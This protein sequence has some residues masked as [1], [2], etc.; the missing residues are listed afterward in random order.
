[1]TSPQQGVEGKTGL[2]P[3]FKAHIIDIAKL[4]KVNNESKQ[5]P[6]D[7]PFSS[8]VAS[9]DVIDPPFNP[10]QLATMP[11]INSELGPCINAM[12][13]N[14]DG[15]G[16]RLV[17][18]IDLDNKKV[19]DEL[20]KKVAAESIRM[21]NFFLYAGLEKSFRALRKDT[22]HDLETT[23]NAYWE[24]VRGPT[25]DIQYFKLMKS[26]QVRLTPES[27]E[28]IETNM[29]IVEIQTDGSFEIKH[30]KVMRR[31]RKFVQVTSTVRPA[32]SSIGYRQRWF[33]AF[34]DPRVMDNE[35]GMIIEGPEASTY[36][37]DKRANEVI[38]FK[39]YCPRSP[40]GLPRYIGVLMSLLGDRKS[41][42]INYVTLCNNN[43]P[44]LLIAVSNGY[45]TEGSVKRIKEYFEKLQGDENRSKVLVIEAESSEDDSGEE[46]GQSRIMIKELTGAQHT[47]AMYQEYGKGN[48][49]RIRVSY[50]LPPIFLG[51]SD[52]YTRATAESSRKLADEQ[53]FNPERE[54]FDD[55]MN[56]IV[57]PAMNVIYHLFKS[58]SPNT[59]DNTELVRILSGAEKTGGMTPRIAR[60]V[61][62]DV[63]GIDLPSFPDDFDP[64]VPFSLTM[65]EAVKNLADA[66]EPGQ[67]VTAVKKLELL[68]EVSGEDAGGAWVVDTLLSL[69][70]QLED[71]W[72]Q[73]ARLPEGSEEAA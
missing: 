3:A 52:D 41:E 6:E 47:D 40:Y 13:G 30:R 22:R 14:I 11:E 26:Y 4:D 9:G 1:M 58:N 31:F 62:Q 71:A 65:A 16:Y 44:S 12:K 70:S 55:F 51:R 10:F 45:L 67:Q 35:S 64:D 54:D 25:G 59:T 28:A 5:L 68:K 7:D 72:E 50:R 66:T 42:E 20:R 60:L 33:K 53:V 56:R 23:G 48:R 49:E 36:P 18:R 29:P 15:F 27:S 61:L 57:F 8:L 34:G 46:L 24:V 17:S 37:E 73:S 63:L 38:H 32:A 19:P 69:R 2:S 39:I 21:K 43:I